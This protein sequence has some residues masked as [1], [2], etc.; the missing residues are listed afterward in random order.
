MD[1]RSS[2]SFGVRSEM[3][4]FAEDSLQ[5]QV[6]KL[7]NDILRNDAM[8]PATW[9]RTRMVAIFK[10]GDD[11]QPGNYRPIALIQIMYMYK[12]FSGM[13]WRRLRAHALP[14][15]SVEQAAYRPSFRTVDLIL[16]SCEILI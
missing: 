15:H 14:K 6:L 7:F 11:R 5:T 12:L 1:L 8:L 2:D 10:K 16:S 9:K 3:L 4:K 13:V